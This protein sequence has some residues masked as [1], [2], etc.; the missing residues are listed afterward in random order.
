MMCQ[1][2]RAGRAS[3][4]ASRERRVEL[5]RRT[6]VR[7]G[8]TCPACAAAHG[9][10]VSYPGGPDDYCV[11]CKRTLDAVERLAAAVTVLLPRTSGAP[12]ALV[13]AAPS[14][15]ET[16]G[17]AEAARLLHTTPDGVYSMHSRG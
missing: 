10:L 5:D 2:C 7:A 8:W 1:Q 15:E 17:V 3:S 11:G 12:V 16:C 9:G 13:P 6:K 14:S 4:G